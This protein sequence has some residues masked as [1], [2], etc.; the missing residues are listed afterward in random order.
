MRFG[1]FELVFP[2][3][4]H[5]LRFQ[6]NR[7]F[8]KKTRPLSRKK[9]MLCSLARHLSAMDLLRGIRLWR[10][11]LRGIRLWP[12]WVC[13]LTININWILIYL[14]VLSKSDHSSID[15]AII[16]IDFNFESNPQ[17][18]VIFVQFGKKQKTS[19]SGVNDWCLFK[20]GILVYSH[21]TC[22]R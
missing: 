12:C 10:C 19:N 1:K 22:S 8:S 6:R 17:A 3:L 2:F 21:S 7:I 13:N 18:I 20:L 16:G 14:C 15:S 9:R 11:C 5:L 4:V